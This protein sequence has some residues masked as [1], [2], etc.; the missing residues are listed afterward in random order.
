[1]A[2]KNGKSKKAGRSK[3]G[4]LGKLTTAKHKARRVKAEAERQERYALTA[5]DR[6]GKR[7]LGALRR[8][9]RRLA[10]AKKPPERAYLEKVRDTVEAALHGRRDAAA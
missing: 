2:D 4:D 8:I 5:E 7:R 10:Q 6:A 1:M 9:E 3:K